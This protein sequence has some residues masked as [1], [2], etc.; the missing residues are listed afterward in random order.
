VGRRQLPPAGQ[1]GRQQLL[2]QDRNIGTPETALR[3]V[4]HLMAHHLP[5]TMAAHHYLN[6]T[7][8]AP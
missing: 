4:H 6:W 2:E 8:H 5:N 3:F 1:I 7:S